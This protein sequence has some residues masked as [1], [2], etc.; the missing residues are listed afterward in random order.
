MTTETTQATPAADDPNVQ[1]GAAAP[2]TEEAAAS[3]EQQSQQ[4][5]GQQPQ[6]EG[7]REQPKREPWFNRR[8]DELTKARR[9]AER[10][11][12]ALEAILRQRDNP[13]Q[14]E[15]PQAQQPQADPYQLAEQIANQRTLNEA[16]NRTYQAGK[17]AYGDDFDAAVNTLR[18]VT[19][20]S[21]RPDF[22]EAVVALPNAHEVYHHL[23][24]NPDDAA[25]VLSLSPVKMAMELATLSAKVGRPKPQSRAPAPITPV[26]KSAAPASELVDELPTAEWMARREA[27]LAK[28]RG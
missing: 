20:L 19:D 4:A 15:T 6:E 27:Q 26:G 10:R 9:E 16:A 3:G 8:I 25:H 28:R 12:E 17:E 24:K 14:Q 13:G 11:A 1:N 21:Q 2:A 7:Q 23:G 5:E 18:Q 22:L